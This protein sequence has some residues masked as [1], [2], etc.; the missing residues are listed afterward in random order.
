[1]ATAGMAWTTVQ[2]WPITPSAL[3]PCGA[4]ATPGWC[5]L[6]LCCQNGSSLNLPEAGG[7]QICEVGCL[8]RKLPSGA[9]AFP[10]VAQSSPTLPPSGGLLYSG[11]PLLPRPYGRVGRW[12]PLGGVCFAFAG[13]TAFTNLPRLAENRSAKWA[14][15]TTERHSTP[16]GSFSSVSAFDPSGG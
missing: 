13:Q 7:K 16:K 11:G 14:C 9:V 2:W 15:L 8:I 3:R 4:M 10:A 6:R 5:L 1:M 12:P